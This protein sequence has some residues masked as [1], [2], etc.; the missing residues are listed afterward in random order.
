M[1]GRQH[2]EFTIAI[3]YRYRKKWLFAILGT[4]CVFGITEGHKQWVE[5]IRYGDYP[6]LSV[7]LADCKVAD[8]TH[9]FIL[10]KVDYRQFRSVVA[11]SRHI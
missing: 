5:W 8:S 7:N 1:H 2:Y 4:L 6:T 10:S 11:A 9:T 3:F